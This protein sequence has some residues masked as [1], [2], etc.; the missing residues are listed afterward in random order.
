MRRIGYLTF[1]GAVRLLTA[2]GGLWIL[3][4]LA[5][6]APWASSHMVRWWFGFG[7]DASA[8]LCLLIG[9]VAVASRRRVFA[10]TTLYG[11]CVVASLGVLSFTAKNNSASLAFVL[12]FFALTV[13]APAF[14]A[15]LCYYDLRATKKGGPKAAVS[16]E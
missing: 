13:T 10:W 1:N 9:T 8:T 5:A 15:L 11:A 4:L 14:V 2:L 7:G 16:C 3:V 6:I 12:I